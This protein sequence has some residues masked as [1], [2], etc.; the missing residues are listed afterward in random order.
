LKARTVNE[1]IKE[2]CQENEYPEDIQDLLYMYWGEVRKQMVSKKEPLLFLIG[3]GEFSINRKKLAQQI[4]KTHVLIESMDKKEYKG[5]SKYNDIVN[6][7]QVYKELQTKAY[8]LVHA[9]NKFKQGLLNDT[10][11]KNNLEE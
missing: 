4:A 6:R 1:L 10:E 9:R 11:N 7:L 8:E 3:L 5:I 2:Y